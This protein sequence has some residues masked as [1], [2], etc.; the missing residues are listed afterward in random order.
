[1][2][3]EMFISFN[4]FINGWVGWFFV[5]LGMLNFLPESLQS[6]FYRIGV[7]FYDQQVDEQNA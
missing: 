4:N 2:I 7:W 3:T 1:M 6:C 5:E